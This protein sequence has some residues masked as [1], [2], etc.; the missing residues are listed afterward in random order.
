MR[1]SDIFSCVLGILF[2]FHHTQA[3]PS[4]NRRVTCSKSECPRSLKFRYSP[5]KIYSY[6]YEANVASFVD[7][8]SGTKESRIHLSA[9]VHFDVHTPCDWTLRVQDVTL[10]DSDPS[11]ATQKSTVPGEV[12]FKE[13]LERSDLSFTFHDGGVPYICP[14]IDEPVWSVNIKRGI[15]SSFQ[16]TMA[17]F[18]IDHESLDTD[19]LGKCKVDYVFNGASLNTIKVMKTYNLVS[20]TNRYGFSDSLP[21]VPYRFFG[22]G[23]ESIPLTNSTSSCEQTIAAHRIIQSECEEKH[24][25]R[26]FSNDGSGA[27]TTGRQSLVFIDEMPIDENENGNS[28]VKEE[29]PRKKASLL[30]QHSNTGHGSGTDSAISLPRILQSLCQNTE[31][32]IENEAAAVFGRLVRT[33]RT[34]DYL[35]LGELMTSADE[36]C[37]D[38]K[39]A[40]KHLLNGLIGAAT[41]DAVAA[42]KDEAS[43][44]KVDEDLIVRWITSLAFIP[45]PTGKHLTAALPLLDMASFSR[46]ASLSISSMAKKLCING[47]S[48]EV[49]QLVGKLSKQLGN[50]CQSRSRE[51]REE[52]IL[53][54]K[55]LSNVGEAI[56]GDHLSTLKQ[57]FEEK[58]N[59][60]EARVAALNAFR[61]TPCHIRDN[62]AMNILTDSSEDSEIRI[63]AYLAMMK[64][65]DYQTILTV[66]NLLANEE[67]NQVG[68]FIWTHLKN[69]ATTSMPSKLEI[70]GLVL[71]QTLVDKFDTDA[72]KFSRNYEKSILLDQYN[73][74]VGLEGNIIFS[75]H[76]YLPRSASLNLTVDI[77]GQSVNL[78]EVDGR[79]ESFE[80]YIESLFGPGGLYPQKEVGYLL[81]GLRSKQKT[82]PSLNQLDAGKLQMMDAQFDAGSRFKDEP[83][84]SLSMKIFGN[85]VGFGHWEGRKEVLENIQKLN[86]IS[87]L[88]HLMN[89]EEKQFSYAAQYIDS[90]HTL[91]LA[92]GLPLNLVAQGQVV[93]DIRGNMRTDLKSIFSRGQGEI[94]WK[95]HPSAAI[96]FN[97]AITID[98]IAAKAGVTLEATL[99]SSISTSGKFSLDGLKLIDVQIDLPQEKAEIIAFK[100]ELTITHRKLKSSLPGIEE[101]RV[102]MSD[103]TRG[104]T[105]RYLGLQVCSQIAYPN[106]SDVEFVPYFPLTGPSHLSIE[107][108]KTDPAITSYRFLHKVENEE[109]KKAWTLSFR[110]EGAK[111]S[112]EVGVR[113]GI[114]YKETDSGLLEFILMLPSNSYETKGTFKWKEETKT[115]E[116]SLLRDTQEKLLVAKASLNR[117]ACS[118]QSAA[119]CY[120]PKLILILSNKKLIDLNGNIKL[121]EKQGKRNYEVGLNSTLGDWRTISKGYYLMDDTSHV[122]NLTIDYT[123]NPRDRPE[124][125]QIEVKMNKKSSQGLNQYDIHLGIEP[126]AY[127]NRNFVGT[128]RLQ[129]GLGHLENVL[130]MNVGSL[131][132]ESRNSLTIQQGFSYS[133]GLSQNIKL[134]SHFEMALPAKGLD[135]AL[136]IG[137]EQTEYR[138]DS[139]FVGRYA[140]G[141]ELQCGFLFTKNP[142]ILLKA[143]GAFNLTLPSQ[144]VIKLSVNIQEQSKNNYRVDADGVWG[145]DTDFQLSSRYD[146][147]VKSTHSSQQ[148]VVEVTGSTIY[149]TEFTYTFETNLTALE[150]RLQSS[151]GKDA[152]SIYVLQENPTKE[153]RKV[154][155]KIS[156]LNY[157]HT[158]DA[159]WKELPDGKQGILDVHIDKVMDLRSDFSTDVAANGRRDVSL[160]VQWDPNRN[161]QKKFVLKTSFEP[162]NL[163]ADDWTSAVILSYPGSFVRG[164][165]AALTQKNNRSISG[166]IDLGS[167]KTINFQA[168]TVRTDSELTSKV[169]LET[170]FDG[171]KFSKAV[172]T[173][174]THDLH[175]RTQIMTNWGVNSFFEIGLDARL[176]KGVESKTAE[177]SC[178]LK[179]SIEQLQNFRVIAKGEML[180]RVLDNSIK[181][182]WGK[183][184]EIGLSSNLEWSFD[185]QF[186]IKSNTDLTT[187]FPQL[188]QV[189]LEFYHNTEWE[190]AQIFETRGSLGFNQLK[191]TVLLKGENPELNK[192]WEASAVLTTPN[193]NYAVIGL[194]SQYVADEK[195]PA[196]DLQI[197]WPGKQVGVNF[198][199][200]ISEGSHGG[201]LQ[202]KTPFE[203]LRNFTVDGSFSPPSSD[204]HGFELDLG[205]RWNAIE[206]VTFNT[207]WDVESLMNGDLLVDL[208][209]SF[210]QHENYGTRLKLNIDL[211]EFPSASTMMTITFPSSQVGFG[212]N[213][214]MSEIEDGSS[215]D[216]VTRLEITG[217]PEITLNITHET[218]GPMDF[219]LTTHLSK[220]EQFYSLNSYATTMDDGHFVAS[221]GATTPTYR[222]SEAE[223]RIRFLKKIIDLAYVELAYETGA[224]WKEFN[225]EK[226]I[227]GRFHFLTSVE[228]NEEFMEK[229]TTNFEF[230]VASPLEMIQRLTV[231]AKLVNENSELLPKFEAI[232][233]NHTLGLTG[234]INFIT[235]SASIGIIR[236]TPNQPKPLNIRMNSTWALEDDKIQ[237]KGVVTTNVQGFTRIP[238][239]LE[240]TVVDSE[241]DENVRERI[242]VGEARLSNSQFILLN[243]ALLPAKLTANV[244]TPFASYK[245]VNLTLDYEQASDSATAIT[246][247]VRI[248][249]DLLKITW[250]LDWP[251]DNTI[252]VSSQLTV[253]TPYDYDHLMFS[254]ISEDPLM[255]AELLTSWHMKNQPNNLQVR[256]NLDL[257]TLEKI[258]VDLK[259]EMY[260]E[261]QK[262]LWA[263]RFN[264]DTSENFTGL[265]SVSTPLNQFK[266]AELSASKVDKVYKLSAVADTLPISGKLIANF[267]WNDQGDI[268]VD[269]NLEVLQ[270]CQFDL[271]FN[272]KQNYSDAILDAS[273][274]WDPLLIQWGI[275]SKL[276]RDGW[277]KYSWNTTV[278]SDSEQK[279]LF[280]IDVDFK[281]ISKL[282]SHKVRYEAV[283][284]KTLYSTYGSLSREDIQYQ[285]QLGVDWGASNPIEMKF[286]NKKLAKQLGNAIIEI[287]TPW[288]KEP[289][290]V[291]DVTVDARQHPVELKVNAEV[292]DRIV[293]IGM[294]AKYSSLDSMAAKINLIT[295]KPWMPRASLKLNAHRGRVRGR[296]SF[297]GSYVLEWSDGYAVDVN[298]FRQETERDSHLGGRNVEGFV[299]VKSSWNKLPE[300]SV[301]YSRFVSPTVTE[302][303]ISLSHNFTEKIKVAYNSTDKSSAG[304]EMNDGQLEFSGTLFSGGF[305]F[306]RLYKYSGGKNGENLPT[307]LNRILEIYEIGKRPHFNLRAEIVE[308][309]TFTG[310]EQVLKLSSP[311][312]TVEFRTH[313][314]FPDG[315]FRH[316]SEFRWRPDA[317]ISYEIDIENKTTTTATDYVMTTSL[318]TP[319]RSLGLTGTLR[320]TKRNLRAVGEVVWDLN[321]RD[322][323]AKMTV[324]WENTTKTRDVDVDRV[325]IAFS[326]GNL[327]QE[328]AILTDIRRSTRHPLDMRTE[329]QYSNEPERKLLIG[330]LVT[331][332]PGNYRY[333]MNMTHQ[334]TQLELRQILAY[335][336]NS[337]G[338]VQLTHLFSHS[339]SDS[340]LMV[341]EHLFVLDHQEKKLVFSASSPTMTLR[342]LGQLVQS[343]NTSRMTYEIQQDDA[344]PRTAELTYSSNLPFARLV[345][346]FNPENNKGLYMNAGMQDRRQVILELFNMDD[347]ERIP[348][349][350]FAFRLNNSRLVT[351]KTQWPTDWKL[352]LAQVVDRT[353]DSLAL[354]A[355]QWVSAFLLSSFSETVGSILTLGD[356]IALVLD[357]A[358][359]NFGEEITKLQED[360][361]RMKQNIIEGYYA[362]AFFA[363]LIVEM[364]GA[365]IQDIPFGS[366]AHSFI[367]FIEKT[368]NRILHPFT[369][370]ENSFTRWLAHLGQYFGVLSETLSS[371]LGD[372]WNWPTEG[373]SKFLA[374]MNEVFSKIAE[375]YNH[376]VEQFCNNFWESIPE[377]AVPLRSLLHNSWN[378]I[379]AV[380]RPLVL[381]SFVSI[382][383]AA[384]N[385]T[386]ELLD[387]FYVH[388][389]AVVESTYFQKLSLLLDDLKQFYVDMQS[390]DW[391]SRIRKYVT[392]AGHFLKEKYS[393]LDDYLSWLVKIRSEVEMIYQGFLKEN[394]ELQKGAENWLKFMTLIQWCYNHIDFNQKMADLVALLRERG[395]ELWRQTVTDAQ[396]RY[397]MQKTMFKFNPE[398]GYI[399]L[400][401]KLPFP[402]ISLDE[403]P[404]FDQLPEIQKVQ[405]LVSFFQPSNTSMIDVLFSY[406]PRQQQLSSLLPPFKSSA[407]LIG[408]QHFTTFDGRHF[409]FVGPCTYLLARDF[410]T[411]N[412]TLAVQY[413]SSRGKPYASVLQLLIDDVQWDLDLHNRTIRANGITQMLPTF[414]SRTER[415]TAAFYENGKLVIESFVKGVRLECIMV[416]EA[417]TITLSGWYNNKVAGMLGTMDNEPTTDLI[418][419]NRSVE[420]DLNSLARSWDVSTKKDCKTIDNLARK[421]VAQ[422]DSLTELCASFFQSQRSQLKK[423]LAVIDPSPYVNMCL[424][425]SRVKGSV[426]D[427]CH[428]AVA[429]ASACAAK[430]VHLR[431]PSQCIR[432]PMENESLLEGET[433]DT[434]LDKNSRLSSDVVVLLDLK[435]CN[436]PDAIS[437]R[438]LPSLISTLEKELIS[439]KITKNR[440]SLI[441][442][443]GQMPY[444][445]P[446][447]RTVNGQEFVAAKE[448]ANLFE[449]LPYGN[450]VAG[451]MDALRLAS[452]LN[453]RP[454]V[455]KTF[456]LLPCSSCQSDHGYEITSESLLEQDATIHVLTN[457]EFRFTKHNVSRQ[458]LGLDATTGF[459]PKEFKGRL[460]GDADLRRQARLPR[461]LLGICAPIALETNGTIF[462]V[463]R[464]R[465]QRKNS[466][467]SKRA[468]NVWVKRVAATA[469]TADCQKCTCNLKNYHE[470]VLD[471][472]VCTPRMTPTVDTSFLFDEATQ[473]NSSRSN[474]NRSKE[475]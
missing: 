272:M 101:N 164:S 433:K 34:M 276:K 38:G 200:D 389:K 257:T 397:M 224:K 191:Y 368:G 104:L 245:N 228:T 370:E 17:R 394:P 412:F 94:A 81:E 345:A 88:N 308:K 177:V 153:E 199:A 319:V 147:Q 149:P 404:L 286:T 301:R 454:G 331:S 262:E 212:A 361:E 244:A 337:T 277:S 430:G 218:R 275:K 74:A 108:V 409:D 261:P 163:N 298:V 55:S 444:D 284:D 395:A 287:I 8:V 469:R 60:T 107:L 216:I 167:K 437:A 414:G 129:R 466:G 256:Y 112:K 312:R 208:K 217:I 46:Q 341:L 293:I 105:Q 231:K 187:P 90:T 175:H 290:L 246:T 65:A 210:H 438:F 403:T 190:S 292:A 270:F 353:R 303:G 79:I 324:T 378:D 111:E 401:Q 233:N 10:Q 54:L 273:A 405:S 239:K 420:L 426:Q 26:P 6:R 121:T 416:Y 13:T 407:H 215:L 39:A 36:M 375:E 313:S 223:I 440:Y 455:S 204:P 37:R 269:T 53:A 97:G 78:F 343:G 373:S 268:S 75:Q 265:V 198:V 237:V 283:H 51:E 384:W 207:T 326:Q 251:Q 360:V 427:G 396:L 413:V 102:E 47:C 411:H 179:S 203:Q 376:F 152:V 12:A 7:G 457:G 252:P 446:R 5:G 391:P 249:E 109:T 68:S 4:G 236:K 460:L 340:E 30:F 226:T 364:G 356:D 15:L 214:S 371:W 428:A 144:P 141:K 418:L 160:D 158:V 329:I 16:N 125:I 448:T 173:S 136:I 392:R 442:F 342:H 162:S 120:Q 25:L 128:W 299:Q 306:S 351:S 172:F 116:A 182:Q 19:V 459:T 423:C 40:R 241:E 372:Q 461:S 417:C 357:T 318:I 374:E 28:A 386:K 151:Y 93:A 468:L 170:P 369:N 415:G 168:S 31:E 248:N 142:G 59:P 115:V 470:S 138:T 92:I 443:G 205:A 462:A 247:E 458:F 305:A 9:K 27:T 264:S 452:L 348:C 328:L 221:L 219:K 402:W 195:Q 387:Y 29:K 126:T 140:P 133:V 258:D 474:R 77:F 321:R 41:S 50:A 243:A 44:G 316:G 419:P 114:E 137:H 11:D 366:Y 57:C 327:P 42:M 280:D 435:K 14:S 209:T 382:E 206:Y 196:F 451:T 317:T 148:L 255:A 385:V 72:R 463:S 434:N 178:G 193:P 24:V 71:D 52:I 95:I 431:I 106:A 320:Q 192:R 174:E 383:A 456:I 266:N 33:L 123:S 211:A 390:T 98:A 352:R 274:V 35:A 87:K 227:S 398:F 91:P 304:H 64:C 349:F 425:K 473:Q 358:L 85:E 464:L 344:T 399:V 131:P 294:D 259:L 135:V 311:S 334:A 189:N 408:L 314:D 400:E 122:S 421:S 56:S 377:I 332:L 155:T 45:R 124:R 302:S 18:D 1:F 127:P 61:T 132:R 32:G 355:D 250:N 73:A 169:V 363:K 197:N 150:V 381:R 67:V 439:Q 238:W 288:S 449:N 330:N 194:S 145:Q 80:R 281:N 432:C 475:E 335:E 119:L 176:E 100:S 220:G 282:Y 202:M 21:S 186:M 271:K 453:F 103:C 254:W 165:L 3:I 336:R 222:L 139:V 235:E 49:S 465:E 76:S 450:G 445:S 347:Q 300:A 201:R 325:K 86:P 309:E 260:D 307:S 350:D 99:H 242:V 365:I 143:S 289:S 110:P 184:Q 183:N 171:W 379:Y 380:I 113:A 346:Q 70:Q 84:M 447:V 367:A 295:T 89:G 159:Y 410:L 429:Y 467:D 441:V 315:V 43:T 422:E 279:W 472:R 23:Y 118:K 157:L 161:P 62:T 232:Y 20:C 354:T 117:S 393:D 263:F 322:S 323:V 406:L 285:G 296:E 253:T 339:R 278:S 63:A 185:G 213:G 297:N 188:S 333:E 180:P 166:I 130:M 267:S 240:I 48:S 436:E 66:K 424:I 156:Y 388:R 230:K 291:V 338:R 471:C 359:L 82:S 58:D 22:A 181:I 310:Q 229:S 234:N 2:F 362:D 134:K 154:A 146:N 225:E 96:N 83:E 69:L